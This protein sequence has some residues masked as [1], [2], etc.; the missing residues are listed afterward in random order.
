MDSFENMLNYLLNR[1]YHSMDKLE[2]LMLKASGSLPLS[3]SE[4][5]TLEAVANAGK[6]VPGTTRRAATV[7][8]ISSYLDVRLPTATSA[9]SKLAAKG[10][11][12]KVK[13]PDDG[14]VVRVSL[15]RNGM[16]AER[17]HQYFHR[18]MVRAVS[19]DLTDEEKAALI[20]GVAKLDSFLER[21]IEKYM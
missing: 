19:A 13:C 17:A 3:I 5:H 10:F 6:T 8:E 18:N 20:K 12:E 14:R 9:V 11:V 2:E 7:S 1:V 16:R 15:T 4:I 21:N